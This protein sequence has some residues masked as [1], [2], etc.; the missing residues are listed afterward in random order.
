MCR[1]HTKNLIRLHVLWKVR[2]RSW[3]KLTVLK[4]KTARI[5]LKYLFKPGS[6]RRL[7]GFINDSRL[8]QTHLA[9]GYD[10]ICTSFFFLNFN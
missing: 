10:I 7:S 2:H 9:T 3:F 5:N 6:Y 8:G 1:V 4:K